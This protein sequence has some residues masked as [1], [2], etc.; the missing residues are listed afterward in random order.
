M[1]SLLWAATAAVLFCGLLRCSYTDRTENVANQV[2]VVSA[3]MGKQKCVNYR[4]CLTRNHTLEPLETQVTIILHTTEMARLEYGPKQITEFTYGSVR[5]KLLI[6][7]VVKITT[8]NCD[9]FKRRHRSRHH[10]HMT[11][12]NFLFDNR[13]TS[14]P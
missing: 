3:L 14:R 2:T 5:R 4:A 1:L 6:P 10:T 12:R 13:R 9:I 7:D 11:D 8:T